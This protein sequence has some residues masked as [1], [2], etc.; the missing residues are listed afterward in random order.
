MVSQS[1]AILHHIGAASPASGLVPPPGSAAFDRFNQVLSFLN[2]NFFESFAPLWYALEHGKE[3][4]E[5]Q[6]L[7]DMGHH[8]VRKAH[9]DLEHMRG[10][11]PWLLGAQRTAADAYFAG[12]ARWNDFHHVLD[13]ND[14]PAVHALCERLQSDPAVQFA[15]AIEHGEAGTGAGGFAG[16]VDLAAMVAPLA[17]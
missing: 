17:S 11:A 5:K 6:A 9:A 12:I 15:H 10:G 2:S 1:V 3:G 7:V 4:L 16:H 14:F 13:R 8:K